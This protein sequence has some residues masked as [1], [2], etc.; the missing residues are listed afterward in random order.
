MLFDRQKSQTLADT[1]YVLLHQGDKYGYLKMFARELGDKLVSK[2]DENG[3]LEL[4][5]G[6]GNQAE[7]LKVELRLVEGRPEE[8]SFTAMVCAVRPQ[9]LWLPARLCLVRSLILSTELFFQEE[10]YYRRS[11]SLGAAPSFSPGGRRGPG[12][13]FR[14]SSFSPARGSPMARGR[15]GGAWSP[16]VLVSSGLWN[17]DGGRGRGR[18]ADAARG[19]GRDVDAARGRGTAAVEGRGLGDNDAG[20]WSCR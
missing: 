16:G 7:K 13:G 20:K 2:A 10:T 1:G 12:R 17:L 8:I 11:G 5:T 6:S 18:A 15:R 14:R 19:R 9:N 4:Q 3:M